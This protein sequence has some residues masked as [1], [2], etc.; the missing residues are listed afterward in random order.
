ME[1]TLSFT[2]ARIKVI[3]LYKHILRGG[4]S[5]FNSGKFRIMTSRNAFIPEYS[6]NLID[7]L[8]SSNLQFIK[9]I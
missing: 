2:L 7:F 3:H 8:K 6:P 9:G 1:Y 5:Y 4:D